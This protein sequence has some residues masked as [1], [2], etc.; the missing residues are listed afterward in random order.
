MCVYYRLRADMF[1]QAVY[2]HDSVETEILYLPRTVC[3]YERPFI[4]LPGSEKPRRICDSEWHTVEIPGKTNICTSMPIT[5]SLPGLLDVNV[6]LSLP[7]KLR[8]PSGSDIPFAVTL[9]G[10]GLSCVNI[11]QSAAGLKIALVKTSTTI[12]KGTVCKEESVVSIGRICYVGEDEH[13]WHDAKPDDT[14]PHAVIRGC[15]EAGAEGKDVSWGI[16]GYAGILYQ[17]RVGLALSSGQKDESASAIWERSET[18]VITSHEWEGQAATSLPALS[19]E[20]ALRSPTSICL[21]SG[22]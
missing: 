5:S 3:H 9:S 16:R 10:P 2:S 11:P 4:P 20:A 6:H 21:L 15:L 22:T 19:L 18:V 12:I 8:F 1:R 7:H 13:Q 14:T 17:V